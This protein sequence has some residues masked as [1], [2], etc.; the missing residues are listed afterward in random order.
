MW[1]TKPCIDFLQCLIRHLPLRNFTSNSV[2]VMYQ[3]QIIH[4]TIRFKHDASCIVRSEALRGHSDTSVHLVLRASCTDW[5][6]WPLRA[7][8]LTMQDT[9]CLNP[10][11]YNHTNV[12]NQNQYHK[13]TSEIIC[14]NF[15]ILPDG[16][17]NLVMECEMWIHL[18]IQY[19]QVFGKC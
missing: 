3:N 19:L 9:S 14:T 10:Q 11:T 15:Y 6:S 8:D 18:A 13:S 4:V 5:S 12:Q 17:L 2:F 7:S 16:F 1:H